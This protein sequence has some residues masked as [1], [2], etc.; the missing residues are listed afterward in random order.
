M[1]KP[2]TVPFFM[3]TDH[4]T[5]TMILNNK[6]IGFHPLNSGW[7]QLF[8]RP[9]F[10]ILYLITERYY[11]LLAKSISKPILDLIKDAWGE[12][13]T[14]G[15][16]WFNPYNELDIETEIVGE[17]CP[18]CGSECGMGFSLKLQ[19]DKVIFTNINIEYLVNDEVLEDEVEL[20]PIHAF[21]I[22]A[23]ILSIYPMV[24][25]EDQFIDKTISFVGIVT[26][27][28]T[29]ASERINSEFGTDSDNYINLKSLEFTKLW[30]N[31]VRDKVQNGN[32]TPE[33]LFSF[34]YAKWFYWLKN[35]EKINVFTNTLISRLLKNEF[36]GPQAVICI[37]ILVEYYNN[38]NS[39]NEYTITSFI[40]DN[41]IEINDIAKSLFTPFPFKT[42]RWFDPPISNIFQI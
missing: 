42:K 5:A 20:D 18:T 33:Q 28:I 9:P 39:E 17:D 2:I 15:G 27:F 35:D 4:H 1:I 37:N 31:E 14:L 32:V 6:V 11:N 41:Q 3:Q 29:A 10:K 21:Y 30:F 8:R 36:R 24:F 34:G 40:E 16:G 13:L 38:L 12:F 19:E 22:L 25:H 23:Y 7:T 26:E